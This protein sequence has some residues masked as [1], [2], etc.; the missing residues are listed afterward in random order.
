MYLDLD[1]YI[2]K[3]IALLGAPLV[4]SRNKS[5]VNVGK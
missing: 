4:F 2:L 5:L 1:A 3:Q